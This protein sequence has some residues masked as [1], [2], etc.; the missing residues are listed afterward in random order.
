[1]ESLILSNVGAAI[2]VIKTAMTISD[3]AFKVASKAMHEAFIQNKT[4]FERISGKGVMGKSTG[5]TRSSMI[6]IK[7]SARF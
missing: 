3:R 6:N 7:C 4:T 5:R 1:M 2:T